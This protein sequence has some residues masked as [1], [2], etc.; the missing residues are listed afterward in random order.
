M[1]A[2]SEMKGR[3]VGRLMS[4]QYS[5][6]TGGH[7]GWAAVRSATLPLPRSLLFFR[8]VVTFKFSSTIS[9]T[10]MTMAWSKVPAPA[11]APPCNPP[12]PHP[13]YSAEANISCHGGHRGFLLGTNPATGACHP[14]SPISSGSQSCGRLR[15]PACRLQPEG[16]AR[17]HGDLDP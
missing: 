5:W 2:L 3:S 11:G 8:K 6:R 15:E 13:L 12:L 7:G 9:L 17:Q 14:I 1:L 4:Y 16:A 10:A